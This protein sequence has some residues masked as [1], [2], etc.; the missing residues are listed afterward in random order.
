MPNYERQQFSPFEI[1]MFYIL[2]LEVIDYVIRHIGLAKQLL[3]KVL[4]FCEIIT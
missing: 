2:N 4:P 3:G 1:K